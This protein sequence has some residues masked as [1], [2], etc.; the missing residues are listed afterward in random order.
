MKLLVALCATATLAAALPAAAQTTTTT[1]TVTE[2]TTVEVP[3]TV[4]T[5]VTE[6]TVPSVV[7][8][9]ELVRGEILPETVEVIAIP[10][11]PDYGYAIVN[12]RRVIL[13]PNTRTVIEVYN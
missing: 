7:L 6:Q 11:Q 13:D 1:T 3:S 8:E 5:Y 9:G 10:D 2:T 12:D 4:R